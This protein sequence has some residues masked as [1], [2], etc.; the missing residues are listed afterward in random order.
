MRELKCP[1]CGNVFSVDE[2]DLNIGD[3]VNVKLVKADYFDLYGNVI[4]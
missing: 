2:A 1:Q 4:S 3:F